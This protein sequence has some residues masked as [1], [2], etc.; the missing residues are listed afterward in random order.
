[1]TQHFTELEDTPFW[2]LRV[3]KGAEMTSLRGVR[4][5][6]PYLQAFVVCYDRHCLHHQYASG[7]VSAIS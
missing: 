3:L 7:L 5:S 1:M 2:H 6:H 4:L